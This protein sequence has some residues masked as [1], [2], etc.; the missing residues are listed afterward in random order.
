MKRS[1][2]TGLSTLSHWHQRDKVHLYELHTGDEEGATGPFLEFSADITTDSQIVLLQ[3]ISHVQ[4]FS[5]EEGL[6]RKPGKKQRVDALI[7]DLGEKPLADIIRSGAYK[8]HDFAS[9]LKQFFADLPQP[10]LLTR[11]LDAY[12]QASGGAE[13]FS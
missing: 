11:H 6:F 2:G 10:L 1:I 13:Q 12:C 3:L 4:N 5:V 8:C 7:R 9:V